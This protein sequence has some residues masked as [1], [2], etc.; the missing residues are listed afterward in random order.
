MPI[1][2]FYLYQDIDDV[3]ETADRLRSKGHMLNLG[4]RIR[5]SPEG[6]NGTLGGSEEEVAQFHRA[7]VQEVKGAEVDFKLSE[8]G[9]QHFG[10][11]WQVRTCAEVVTMGKEGRVAN[12]RNAAPHLD[13]ETFRDELIRLH[14]TG[15]NNK[16]DIVLL[17]ARNEYESAIGHFD[18]AILPPIRQFSDFAPFVR[19]YANHFE[20][21]R[22]LMYC[23]GGVRC[24]RGSAMIRLATR[25][26]SVAQLKGGI[27]TF[28]KQFPD[29]G[30]V[31]HGKNLVFDKRLAIGCT[32]GSVVG[33]C[34]ICQDNWDDYS[35][36][37]R[38]SYCR[39][40]VLICQKKECTGRWTSDSCRS[41]CRAC[42]HGSQDKLME[43]E[44]CSYNMQVENSFELKPMLN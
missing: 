32:D 28:L 21:K 4:G 35:A 16:P 9:P 19:R 3:K 36:Q 23:T 27:E 29:G 42:S 13:A 12:W 38:C 11:K 33:K 30:G 5:V 1:S 22:V 20:G 8:G 37:W 10:Q 15:N 18:G 2:L 44:S 6:I 7:V 25:A 39:Y 40:R 41:L 14:S 43:E 26:K 17:D 24:E 31:F 34:I